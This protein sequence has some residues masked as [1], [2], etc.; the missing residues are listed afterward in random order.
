VTRAAWTGVLLAQFALPTWNLL[1]AQCPDGS[2]PP[3]KAAVAARPPALHSVAVLFFDNLSRDSAY[4][5]LSDGLTSQITT[6]LSQLKRLEVKSP[7]AVRFF[8]ASTHDTRRLGRELRV[9]YLLEGDVLPGRDRIGVTVRLVGADDGTVRWSQTYGRPSSDLLEVIEDVSREVAQ[10]VAGELLPSEQATLARRPTADPQAY[11]FY[12]RGRSY[13][14]QYT[15][16]GIR[17]A[18]DLYR[19][20]V[21]RDSTFALGWAA[22]AEAWSQLAD[23]WAAPQEAYPHAQEAAERAVALDSMSAEAVVALV[24]PA[25]SMHYDIARAERL[26]RRGIALDSNLPQARID[27]AV[28]LWTR[29]RLEEARAQTERA[30]ALD[31]LSY[32]TVLY[33]LYSLW[34]ERRWDDMDAFVRRTEAV[35]PSSDLPLWEGLVLQGRNE[36]AMAVEKFKLAT[37]PPPYQL[38]E[39]ARALVCVGRPAEARAVIDSLLDVGQRTYIA[40]YNIA[41]VYSVLGQP[42]TAF[43]WLERAYSAHD[44]WLIFLTSDPYWDPLRDDPRFKDLVRR[45]GLPVGETR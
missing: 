25:L 7:S 9:R 35:I 16:A 34:D 13:F 41:A 14:N 2:A 20:A 32:Y 42:D 44:T 26:A 24:W 33:H 21:A 30:W 12:L 17:R 27:L 43:T 22:L 31:S 29:S 4:S 23:S 40:S 19:Q 6:N 11:D 15:E 3:C 28:V 36:C 5:Y 45:V 8:L 38:I 18:I 39:L 10:A 1:H 37:G